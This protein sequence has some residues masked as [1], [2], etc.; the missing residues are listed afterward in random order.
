MTLKV[1]I[2][3]NSSWNLY[4]FRMG[5]M[6]M[7]LKK[8]YHLI[9][10]SPKD[11]YSNMLLDLGFDYHPIR[12]ECHSKNI[13]NE[14]VL[15][16]D[17]YKLL[18]FKKPD[19]VLNY[20][21]KPNIYFSCICR[22]LK[23][24]YVN[25]ITGLGTVYN[26]DN[27]LTKW[28]NFCYKIAFKKS[29]KIFFQNQEDCDFFLSRNI[30]SSEM[31]EIIP[32][33]GVDLQK[34]SPIKLE[35][36]ESHVFQ[37]LFV[38]RVLIDKGIIELVQAAKIL[39]KKGYVFSLSILGTLDKKNKRSISMNQINEW[40]QQGD[41]NYLGFNDDIRPFVSCADCIILPSYREGVPRAL[42]EGASMGK[43]I[44]STDAPGCRGV[45]EDGYN[46]YLC[47]IKDPI[48]LAKKMEQLYLQ[49]YTKIDEMGENSRR[50]IESEF[51]EYLVIEK[52]LKV[53]S[54]LELG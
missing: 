10:V 40:E 6:K 9:A 36:T 54:E 53:I 29:K 13:F 43:P 26:T 46:G 2:S 18:K 30:V 33:S 50:K 51:S 17:I 11:K 41:I 22:I 12:L 44:I 45:V 52:Y 15:C 31:T 8:D 27:L 35:R 32:G 23:I 37:F 42:L 21:I 19:I 39:R 25:T 24:P 3:S 34:Y 1:M 7:I 38:G 5:L 20:T 49:S 28:V 16:Y 14:L 48:D 47:K 4:N